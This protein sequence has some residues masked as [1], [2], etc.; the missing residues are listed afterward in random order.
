MKF[1]DFRTRVLKISQSELARKAQVNQATISVL[2]KG[3]RVSKLSRG[4]LLEA[5]SQHLGREVN[6]DEID[7]LSNHKE[8]IV[9]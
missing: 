7:E 5:M 6:A 3:Q 2:E 4:K 8:G 9:Q 1:E